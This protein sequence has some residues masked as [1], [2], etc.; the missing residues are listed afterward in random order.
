[1]DGMSLKLQGCHRQKVRKS[2]LKSEFLGFGQEML[3]K[4]QKSGINKKKNPGSG[5]FSVAQS[6]FDCRSEVKTDF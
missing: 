1:M 6:N 5:K 2:L 3:K 4:F